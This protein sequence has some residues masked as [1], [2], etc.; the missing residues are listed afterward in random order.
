ML[1]GGACEGCLHMGAHWTWDR[2]RAPIVAL[3]SGGCASVRCNGTQDD[4]GVC[5]VAALGPRP[6]GFIGV[7]PW[8]I[9]HNRAAWLECQVTPG[10]G[11]H[12]LVT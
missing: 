11:P 5:V 9:G 1:Q 4:A 6:P 8:G 10:V 7:S 2:P 3:L 12:P